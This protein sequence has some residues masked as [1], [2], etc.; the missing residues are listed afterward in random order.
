[1]GS[2]LMLNSEVGLGSEFYFI[3]DFEGEHGEPVEYS[4]IDQIKKILVVDDNPVNRAIIR[5]MLE[6]LGV[7]VR[8]NFV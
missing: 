8:N 3:V 1:M 2:E 7:E 4:D 6:P 5:E